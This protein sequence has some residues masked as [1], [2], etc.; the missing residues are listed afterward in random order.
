MQEEEDRNPPAQH[1]APGALVVAVCLLV[2]IGA[3]S[4]STSAVPGPRSARSPRSPRR[5]RPAQLLARAA[6]RR[7][8]PG[9][10]DR[11]HG[12]RLRPAGHAAEGAPSCCLV[13][14]STATRPPPAGPRGSTR[15]SARPGWSTGVGPG[16]RPR[17]PDHRVSE[18][19]PDHGG[20]ADPASR[21]TSPRRRRRTSRGVPRPAAVGRPSPAPAAS[22][23]V[24]TPPRPG[25]RPV[26]VLAD[27]APG[28]RRRIPGPR[29][30]RSW[31]R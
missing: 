8:R 1:A 2:L 6:R 13:S 23:R 28:R 5:G 9:R 26:V 11:R 29:S 15:T 21:S 16:P 20:L 4:P 22:S 27:L 18:V 19:R 24:S 10:P 31:S 14:P 25:L 7:A 12:L 3:S 30:P 17:G